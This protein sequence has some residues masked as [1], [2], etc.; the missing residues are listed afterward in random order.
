MTYLIRADGFSRERRD[1]C[2]R[3]ADVPHAHCP[4]AASCHQFRGPMP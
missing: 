2:A 4:V 1:W 3:L